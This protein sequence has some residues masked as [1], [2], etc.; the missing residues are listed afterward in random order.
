MRKI[1][2][3]ILIFLGTSFALNARAGIII[4]PVIN[5]G[6]VGYWDFNESAGNIAYDKSGKGNHGTL[7]N[8]EE[9]DWVDGQIGKSIK[10]DGD[11]E[12]VNA[13]DINEIDGV[14]QLTITAWFYRS[15]SAHVLTIEKA[16]NGNNITGINLN[17]TTLYTNLGNGS[18]P[19]GSYSYS[20][21]G[22][23][24]VTMVFDGGQADNAT[25]LKLY[26]NGAQVTTSF[27]GTI[28]ATNDINSSDFLMGISN[29]YSLNSTGRMDEVRIYNR[30][31][32][33]SEVGRLY[34]LSSPKMGINQLGL[35]PDDLP[36]N[37]TISYVREDCTG[38]SPC[39]NSLYDWEANY[40]GIDFANHS[41]SNGDLTCLNMTAV[42]KI[43]GTWN[44]PDTTTV[45]I[46]GWTTDATRY[47]KIYTTA[48]ARHNG[49]WGTG[50]MRTNNITISEE[51]VRIDGLSTRMA[52]TTWTS[53]PY[54]IYNSTGPGEI[55]ISNCYGEITN[56]GD[57]NVSVYT[58][59]G[60]G[61]LT[62]KIWNSI[63]IMNSN[64]GSVGTFYLDD[65][66]ATLYLYNN[67]A[68]NYGTT[69]AY[70]RI[71]AGTGI[72]KN[73]LGY[74][75]SGAAFGGTWNSVTYSASDDATADDWG[76]A[77]NR[78]N[79]TFSFVNSGANDY[80]LS[81]ADTG[82][83]DYGVSNPGSGL[84]STDIDRQNRG[85]PWDIGADEAL[86]AKINASQNNQLTDGLVGL[87]SFNGTDIN[88]NEAVDRS[89]QGNNGTITGATK[90]I[91]KVG[92]AL[93]FDGSDDGIALL[94]PTSLDDIETKGGGGMSIS[95]WVYPTATNDD[96]YTIVDKGNNSSGWWSF[97]LSFSSNLIELKFAKDY[98]TTDLDT[99]TA[100]GDVV[101]GKWQHIAVTWD[102]SSSASNIH[103][104]VDGVDKTNFRT[105]GEGDKN[106]D[107]NN[108]VYIAR[109]QYSLYYGGKMDEVRIY[110]RA[111]EPAEIQRLY[112]L[113][114]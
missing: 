63:G 57:L 8:G 111:L 92:Q 109:N 5:T 17:A 70:T 101:A 47:I 20:G 32:S 61:A 73:C 52:V 80:H 37:A 85:V 93:S 7:V 60:V 89:G 31:L 71:S 11:G 62:V 56:S 41:C 95:A 44:S 64:Y 14:S 86:F 54:L 26:I 88:G 74:S 103:L 22:W 13:G 38:Y 94:S 19:Y 2:F 68:I 59:Y 90:T 112:N 82:A 21:T 9:A 34:K 99:G 1:L 98:V 18:G 87:W 24:Y 67:T 106:S 55:Y 83:R 51:N 4:R 40:G 104:Y 69:R 113:G 100:Y 3:I 49:K 33:E 72:I 105:N 53:N 91:G 77:G 36:A 50:Y 48:S 6:L 65:A 76:G 58:V 110:N 12:Y 79:Q 75:A 39:Y 15:S 16:P 107:V 46:S 30:A 97:W 108:D 35:V 81:P 10:F 78:I 114:R 102:G 42:A 45:I 28:P 84:F 66:D 96:Q 25:K 29:I 23:F 27:S 43:D